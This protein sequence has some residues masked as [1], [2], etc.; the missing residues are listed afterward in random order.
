MKKVM[1]Q[2][3]LVSIVLCFIFTSA[4][5]EQQKANADKNQVLTI[6]RNVTSEP[7]NMDPTFSDDSAAFEVFRSIMEG[8]VALDEKAQ[9]Q[10]AIAKEWTVSE[11]GLVYTFKLRPTKWSNGD[12]LTAHDFE[13]AWKRMLD[14]KN[15]GRAEY[16][17]QLFYLK[18]GEKYQQGKAKAEEVG[19]K[20]TSDDT[21]V[22][23]L[24]QPVPYFLSLTSTPAYFP[25]NKKVVESDPNWAKNADTYVSNGPFKI[26]TWIHDQK[27]E[28][29]KNENYWDK[30]KVRL[31]QI[32]L[33]FVN[34][35]QTAYQMFLSN[36]ADYIAGNSIPADLTPQ[37][38]KEGK[39]KSI[40][41]TT[42]YFF[43]FNM[44]KKPLNNEKIR[45]AFSLAIDRKAIVEK[46]AQGGQKVATGLVPWGIP[47]PAANKDFTDAHPAYVPETAKAEEAKRLLEEGMKEEGITELPEITFDYNTGELH[48]KIAETVQQ[49]WKK[50]LGVDVQLRNSELKVFLDRIDKGDFVI[51]RMGI[52]A[53]YLDPMSFL[54]L[55][56]TG[57]D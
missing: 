8:L 35:A 21:L 28:L 31:K 7:A 4:C 41:D 27:I 38:L 26:K 18:N 52:G 16:A 36:Q 2:L 37:L 12:P 44:K 53:D 50:N 20:A 54:D 47:D 24:E 5:S 1:K 32:N 43:I 30:G 25:L 45:R 23:N 46:V 29:V 3:L 51:A 57:G 49:M 56:L 15:K 48:K 9:P 6:I 42:P 14:S 22:V 55:Y 34:S 39:A 33:P 10:P 19:V 17:Y 40:P 13:F 11:D